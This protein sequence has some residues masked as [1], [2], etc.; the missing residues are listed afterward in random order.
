MVSN[1]KSSPLLSNQ[2]SSKDWL[3]LMDILKSF[4]NLEPAKNKV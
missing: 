2:K 3:K 1:N 4:N